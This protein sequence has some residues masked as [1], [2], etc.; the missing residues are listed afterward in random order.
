MAFVRGSGDDVSS[1]SMKCP[2]SFKP[3]RLR[4]RKKRRVGI[5]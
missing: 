1:V 4:S 5:K 3:E 2:Y